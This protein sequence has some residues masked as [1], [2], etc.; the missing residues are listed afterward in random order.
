LQCG[1]AAVGSVAGQRGCLRSFGWPPLAAL[2]GNRAAHIPA[3][4]AHPQGRS[5]L[6]TANSGDARILLLRGGQ[7]VQ[8]TE[9]HVPDNENERNR[10]E[11]FNPNPKMPLV[12]YVGGTWRVGG[13]LALSRAFG[14]AYLKGSDQFEGVSF[15]ASD[16]YASG[17]GLIAEP[18]T[19]VTD[20][21]DDD[22]WIIVTSDGLLANEER[23]GGGGLRWAVRVLAGTGGGAGSRVQERLQERSA[24][25]R[26]ALH[27]CCPLGCWRAD[28]GR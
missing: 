23:G 11:R 2:C 26:S 17:F 15:Y 4:P 27:A 14:D 24:F 22:S 19:S 25:I 8:L 18:H 7:A 9:D 5:Q 3:A 21:T 28:S 10:I 16:T 1:S 6:L 20:L 12:R 13:L